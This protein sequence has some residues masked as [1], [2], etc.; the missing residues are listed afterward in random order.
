MTHGLRVLEGSCQRRGGQEPYA[1]LLGALR[2]YIR[3]RRPGQLRTELQ[4]CAWLVRLLPEL[5]EG[6]IPPLPSWTLTPE[7][8]RRLV[9]EAVLRFLTNVAGPAGTL[10][11]LDDLQWAG[12]DALDLLSTLVHAAAEMSLRVLGA[13]RDTEVATED[14]LT[15]VLSH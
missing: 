15:T 14:P 3:S 8:E 13:Y 7:H 12:P 1:P 2:R 9:G 11:V 5:A 6:P 10:L 4:G